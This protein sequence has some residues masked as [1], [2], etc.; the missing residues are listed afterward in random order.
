MY[1][2]DLES[3]AQEKREHDK[4]QKSNASERLRKLAENRK[5][6]RSK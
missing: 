2:K 4:R 6:K 3:N 5:Q 1:Y